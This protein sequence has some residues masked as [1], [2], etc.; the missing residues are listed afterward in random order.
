MQKFHHF[1]L[2]YVKLGAFFIFRLSIV[3]GV[4]RR[5]YAPYQ[6]KNPYNNK[7]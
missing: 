2:F 6:M 1:L 5:K 7:V 4:F 3:K